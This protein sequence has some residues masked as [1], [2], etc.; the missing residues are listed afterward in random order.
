MEIAVVGTGYVGLVVGACLADL[1]NRVICVDVDEKK[2]EM[3]KRGESPIYE[4]GLDELLER[5]I[6]KQRLSF[7][8]D[9]ERAVKESSIIF[10]A[11]GTPQGK[12]GKADL[13]YVKQAAESIGKAM[14]GEKIIVNKSTVPIG[15]G[16]MVEKIIGQHFKGK[17]HVVS[18]P[19]FLREGSAINDFLQPDRIVIGNS[20]KKAAKKMEELYRPLNA[21]ILFTDVE[22]AEL[23]KY[24]SNAFLATKISFINEIAKLCDKVKADVQM[25]AK[26]VG[27]DK[28]IGPYFLRAGCGWGGSC[29]P[30]DV[31]ALIEIGKQFG[32]E[33]LIP[34]AAEEVN[35]QQKFLPVKKAEKLLG[36]LKGKTITVL[37]LAFKPGTDDMREAPSIEIIRELLKKGAKVNAFDPIAEKE[38]RKIFPSINYFD[39]VYSALEDSDA[40]LLITE[41]NEFK[42]MDFENVKK[43]MNKPIIIDGRNIYDRKT[44][45]KAGFKYEGIGV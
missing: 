33:F 27:L 22:S 38:A 45:E 1:G 39:S 25:V 30:K 19:E 14:N 28:R 44:L 8:T 40:V 23:I 36:S 20:D 3:L 41:W 10:I 35:K 5:N 11:V 26:G 31:S 24:A 15:T 43:T 21:K 4:P 17:F 7:T 9:I 42:E 37:G 32:V 12:N 16:K 13:K 34:K 18:N 6:G 2:I 29:F